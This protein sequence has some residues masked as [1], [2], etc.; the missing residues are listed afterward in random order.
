MPKGIKK[1][2]SHRL[3]FLGGTCDD[4]KLEQELCTNGGTLRLSDKD[5]DKVREVAETTNDLALSKIADKLDYVEKYVQ[6]DAFD[7]LTNSSMGINCDPHFCKA[8][9]PLDI[10]PRWKEVARRVANGV[11]SDADIERVNRWTS[12]NYEESQR[13]FLDHLGHSLNLFRDYFGTYN[14]ISGTLTPNDTL[15]ALIYMTA[16]IGKALMSLGEG[17]GS[18]N[19]WEFSP[20]I[21]QADI[22]ALKDKEDE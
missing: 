2:V 13:W 21:T 4:Y 18:S 7:I 16:R 20:M 12:R 15:N 9:N 14:G 22:D 1:E 19:F 8:K 10:Y 17:A 6:A 5:I 11:G 3:L